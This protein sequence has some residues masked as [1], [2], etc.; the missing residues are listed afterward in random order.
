MNPYSRFTSET[1]ESL[2]EYVRARELEDERRIR[3]DMVLVMT[4]MLA[5]YIIS[6][7][8]KDDRAHIVKSMTRQF[9]RDEF[10]RMYGDRI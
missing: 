3:R 9:V 2:S 1:A 8:V 6:R 7:H 10:K 5:D 4:D